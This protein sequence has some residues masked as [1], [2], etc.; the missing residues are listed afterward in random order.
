M[1]KDKE[2]KIKVDTKT[3]KQIAQV[4]C[5]EIKRSFGENKK[6]YTLAE[7]CK[8]QLNQV[9]KWMQTGRECD[10]PWPGAADYFIPLT[11]WIID[12]VYARV[13][14]ILFS[15]EPYMQAR[16]E[17]SADVDKAAGVTDFVDMVFREKIRLYENS[18]YSKTRLK[19]SVSFINQFSYKFQCRNIT[20]IYDSIQ[21]KF[22]SFV[23]KIIILLSN[24]KNRIMP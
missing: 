24:I 8:N 21:I 20:F 22:I 19:F 4:I 5:A 15:Q 10:S 7:R 23:I 9:T 3:G 6:F 12:A 14:S 17:E 16:G 1:D 2:Y 18:G 11:E 13:M